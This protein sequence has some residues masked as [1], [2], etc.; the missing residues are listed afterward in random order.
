MSTRGQS[1]YRGRMLQSMRKMTPGT[2]G[3]ESRVATPCDC[4]E[5]IGLANRRAHI[6][7]LFVFS[8]NSIWG[9]PLH[10]VP[11]SFVLGPFAPVSGGN[12]NTSSGAGRVFSITGTK[13]VDGRGLLIWFRGSDSSNSDGTG[14]Y[15]EGAYTDSPHSFL[16]NDS[17]T[18]G[19]ISTWDARWYYKAGVRL[20]TDE[21]GDVFYSICYLYTDADAATRGNVEIW[22]A[23]DKNDPLAGFSLHGTIESNAI[24]SLGTSYWQE[25]VYPVAGRPYMVDGSR[26]VY[27]GGKWASAFGQFYCQAGY[28]YSNNHGVTWTFVASYGNSTYTNFLSGQIARSPTNGYLYSQ[29]SYSSVSQNGDIRESQDNGVTWNSVHSYGGGSNGT[30]FWSLYED[31]KLVP[32]YNSIFALDVD[33]SSPLNG[34]TVYLATDAYIASTAPWPTASFLPNVVFGSSNTIVKTAKTELFEV[35]V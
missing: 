25:N 18:A 7:R 20:F 6:P 9:H 35:S 17:I 23:D 12:G 19:L 27:A 4:P 28:W 3:G 24:S 10:K 21:F 31:P 2:F 14:G 16:K 30:P 29:D 8:Q 33:P 1:L 32:T 5:P 11:S 22:K 34:R 15:L 26:W 13:L